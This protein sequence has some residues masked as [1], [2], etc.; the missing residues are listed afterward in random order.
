MF[1]EIVP[2]EVRYSLRGICRYSIPRGSAASDVLPLIRFTSKAGP[3]TPTSANAS[4][5]AHDKLLMATD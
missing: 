5:R 1:I 4:L 3:P 2:E